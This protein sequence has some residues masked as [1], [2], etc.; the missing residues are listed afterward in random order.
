MQ[1][2]EDQQSQIIGII[3]NMQNKMFELINPR[4]VQE[5]KN[6]INS[7]KKKNIKK[8]I[9]QIM[10]RNGKSEKKIQF[11]PQVIEK[12]VDIRMNIAVQEANL[13]I[14]IY[15]R[16]KKTLNEINNENIKL[17]KAEKTLKRC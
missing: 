13:Y 4:D 2:L 3:L 5:M 6:F 17:N 8:E 9:I 11:S 14:S 10:I 1:E 16:T 12:A 7:D 15:E